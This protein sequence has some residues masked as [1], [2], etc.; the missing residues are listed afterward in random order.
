MMR[1][2]T[3][4]IARRASN[5]SKGAT[6]ERIVARPRRQVAPVHYQ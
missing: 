4:H 3:E 5:P 1:D 6:E 2:I